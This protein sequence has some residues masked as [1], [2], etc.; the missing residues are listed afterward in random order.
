MNQTNSDSNILVSGI[1]P[2]GR[3]H[4]GNYFGAM[5]QFFEYQNQYNCF[6]FVADYHA[7]TTIQDKEV[8]R[9]NI[10]DLVVDYLT[11]GLDPKKVTLY[12]QS[13]VP[14]T[15]ELTWIFNCLTSMGKLQRAHAYK[16][17][18]ESGK[19]RINVGLFDYPMLMAA[20]I[21]LPG[22]DVVPTG[23]DQK[24]H[25]EYTR[26]VAEKFNSTFSEAFDLPEAL[27]KDDV[28]TIP[29]LDGQKMSKSYD[30]TIRLFEPEESLREKVMSIV[31]D[32]KGKEEPKDP[33][34]TIFSLLELFITDEEAEDMRQTY[35]SGGVGYKE[36]KERLFEEVNEFIAPL[37]AKRR[38]IAEDEELIQDVLAAGKETVHD[39]AENRM[40][41]IRKEIGLTL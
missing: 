4:L 31:T 20:D 38:E 27:I 19:K 11:I 17:A 41:R 35:A 9:Q 25:I 21:L 13:D 24:Q 5:K 12:K 26:D 1:Q 28:A 10:Y 36:A 14:Q 39:I 18:K 23:Q 37:R 7:L 33:D 15:T 3:P 2:S 29:G 34:D 6:I 32:S 16:A 30:N 22:A 8:M 40:N